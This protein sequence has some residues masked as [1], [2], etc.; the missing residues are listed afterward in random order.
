MQLPFSHKDIERVIVTRQNVSES[1]LGWKAE[2]RG[3]RWRFETCHACAND[4]TVCEFSQ[5]VFRLPETIL[6]G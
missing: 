2:F 4:T 1:R 5:G 3:T 6:E